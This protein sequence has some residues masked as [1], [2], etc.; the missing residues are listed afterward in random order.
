[1]KKILSLTL[2]IL[3]SAT[4]GM[5]TAATAVSTVDEL[6]AIIFD[7]AGVQDSFRS[8]TKE[9]SKLANSELPFEN[10]YLFMYENIVDGPRDAAIKE[11]AS[12]TDYSRNEIEAIVIEGNVEKIINRREQRKIDAAAAEIDTDDEIAELQSDL[13]TLAAELAGFP[14]LQS[15]ITEYFEQKITSDFTEQ[16]LSQS[17]VLEEYSE[18]VLMYERELSFQMENSML[19]Y[20]ALANEIFFD[21]DLSNSA[22]IDILYDLDKLS[23]IL[24]GDTVEYPN[25]SNESVELSSEE[26]E[27]YAGDDEIVLAS[28]EDAGAEAISPYACLEDSG[29]RAALDAFAAGDTGVETGD[30][31]DLDTDDTG[32]TTATS[33]SAV[34]A[35]TTIDD[36][37]DEASE[38]PD[39]TLDELENLIGSLG[40]PGDW[41]RTLP[42]GEFF[43]ITIDFISENDDPAE[44]EYDK[45]DNFISAHLAYI[46]DRMSETLSKSLVP[47]KVSMNWFEDATCKEGGN[48]VNLD[49]NVYTVANPIT[50]DPGDDIDELAQSDIDEFKEELIQVVGFPLPG[51]SKT[52]MGKTMK[53]ISCEGIF[54]LYSSGDFT[55]DISTAYEKCKAAMDE[56]EETK[57]EVIA[58]FNFNVRANSP[59]FEQMAAELQNM[60]VYFEEMQKGLRATYSD[61]PAPLP[62]LIS[63]E[64][65][66]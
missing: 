25:R 11:V 33:G 9:L 37:L 64:Y 45:T 42:C 52:V 13:E 39:E 5:T 56:Y 41:T 61:D 7:E 20:E 8:D 26:D 59:I 46:S 21:G 48:F 50:L 63:K 29:L 65:C 49:F 15:S 22:D 62:D 51:H 60:L 2:G 47:S 19:A 27:D 36:L 23:L 54:N 44:V 66:N 43:C 3:I 38:E 14:E 40:T 12:I 31:I 53:Q 32:S 17:E 16:A 30:A 6:M 57:A 35:T 55:E 34:T 18:I 4:L 58:E 10:L 1:M 24:F 28:E